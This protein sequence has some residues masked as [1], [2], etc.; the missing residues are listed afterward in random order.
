M[1]KLLLHIILILCFAMTAG[2]QKKDSVK[3]R[4]VQKL[5]D[6]A[7]VLQERG[8]DDS[9]L[10]VYQQALQVMNHITFADDP[11]VPLVYNLAGQLY[12]RKGDWEAAHH[13][14]SRALQKARPFGEV[15]YERQL[16][17]VSLLQLHRE[18]SKKDISF[19]YPVVKKLELADVW[20]P[21]LS[22][23]NAGDD[24][25][26][27]TIA[28]GRFDGVG[29]SL[30]TAELFTHITPLDTV[31]HKDLDFYGS[32]RIIR[33]TDNHTIIRVK[34]HQ[35]I[36]LL[37]GDFTILKASVPLAWR[38]LW[39]RSFLINGLNLI[40]NGREPL[41]HYR[42]LYYY[43]D[44]LTRD[45]IYGAMKNSVGEV[46]ELL[47]E[48]TLTH[49][50]YGAKIPSGIFQG[51]NIIRAMHESRPEHLEL[52]V[53][54]VKRFPA[55]YVGNDYRFSETYATWIINNTP[56]DPLNVKSFLLTLPDA[57][58]GSV[59]TKL[60]N[61]ILDDDIIDIWLDEGMRNVNVENITEAQTVARLM[62]VVS[63]AANPEKEGWSDYLF[64]NIERKLNHAGRA[65]SLLG[66]AE[67]KFQRYSLKEGVD[68]VR[69]TKSQWKNAGEI[70]VSVQEGHILPYVL[71]QARDPRYFA[72]GGAD[73]LIK[74]WDR[75]LG[76][77]ILT[78]RGHEEQV[79]A[80][81]YSP[82]G[83]Y[84][85]S[86]GED[87]L[88]NVWNAYNY[89]LLYQY[90][91]PTI[92]KAVRFTPDNRFIVTG[93]EDS[94]V[95]IREVQT[96]KIW[97]T[98]NL[99]K[100]AVNSLA[101]HPLYHQVLYSAG[102]D[103]FVYK[104]DINEGTMTRW[105]KHKGKALSVQVS[106]NGAYFSVVSS[107]SLMQ[108]WDSDTHRKLFW[109]KVFT[110]STGNLR[111]FA[112]ESFTPDSR[113]IAYPFRAD[114]F[115][116]I[117][118]K[119]LYERVYGVEERGHRLM[120]LQ[121]SNDGQAMFARYDLGGPLR[122]YN[123]VGWDIQN[124]PN[125]SWRDIRPF[126]NMVSSV[127][128]TDNDNSLVV[129]H[130]EISKLDLRNG[131]N[132]RLFWGY[133]LIDNPHLLVNG[134]KH[135]TY[136]DN[137]K[138][139][140]YFYD[141][142]RLENVV[143]FSLPPDE[144]LA[145]WKVSPGTEWVWLGS[146]QGRLGGWKANDSLPVFTVKIS[147]KGINALEYDRW[148]QK[149]YV[150]TEDEQ[151]FVVDPFTG[152]LLDSIGGVDGSYVACSPDF[153]YVTG[154]DGYL[155]KI[156]SADFEV[157]RK[158]KVSE[159]GLYQVAINPAKDVLSFISY[160]ELFIYRLS[161]DSLRFRFKDHEF[162]NTMLAISNDGKQIATA[163]LDSKVNLY[164]VASGKLLVNI[165]YPMN[166]GVL[167]SDANGHYLAAKHTLDA[168]QFTY[169]N[170]AYSFDQFDLRLNR[171]DIVLAKIGRAD[172][173][174][175][176]SFHNAFLKRLSRM[177][178]TEEAAGGEMHLPFV[179]LKDRFAVQAA[180]TEQEFEITVECSDSRY[181]LQYVQV[182]VNNNPVLGLKG[183]D[184]SHLRT[185]ATVQTIKVPL[186]QGLNRIKVFCT[187]AKGI[188]SLREDIEVLSKYR[189]E[190]A[191]RTY[192]V[193][194]GTASYKDSRMD[195]QYSVK[196]IRDLT[197]T[198]DD[199]YIDL[200]VDTLIDRKATRENILSLKK[201]LKQTSVND[202]VIL[203][204]TGHG[205]LSD[206]LD[207]Y[208]ATWDIDFNKPEKEG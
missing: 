101:F 23:I 186:S 140:V 115:V 100:G 90:K 207:F 15:F 16:A 62:R 185:Q 65:D 17:F 19:R 129:L 111:F 50:V 108:V 191:P 158:T 22:F 6:S 128:F 114:S 21:V 116:V 106:T 157:V 184:I 56:L 49:E 77:E 139:T 96:G 107:D 41:Y 26:D 30:K 118:I 68:W 12:Q 131:S 102:S 113:Y 25:L 126:G 138:P 136:I 93:G 47:A 20:F 149:L 178:L 162:A 202:R 180:T 199:L 73:K 164:D 144:K 1:K 172:S 32:G 122:I 13:H 33:V 57:E 135:G 165:H 194:I 14:F 123:F 79:T 196:D 117:R 203:A 182:L 169:N 55:K 27:V 52:F 120:D 40:S 75:T 145:T 24:S 5:V 206:S 195:L 146:E 2:A 86:V 28:G 46:V 141:Y 110:H 179:R 29:D 174:L 69:N 3:V 84:L 109:G 160:D 44:S 51:K 168:I 43:Y 142:R 198:F 45:D 188:S 159:G 81:E 37:R 183:M 74:I 98:L 31:Y 4:Q 18:L 9:A 201:K 53:N 192:F 54:F 70:K 64:A 205:L 119:D 67:L 125:I 88:V 130:S 171:P 63:R 147:D 161:D 35:Q 151:F 39:V 204:V 95:R 60:S 137:R 104:W 124:S 152:N 87:S 181:P 61:Q 91:S 82:N 94:V 197:K 85:V 176:R 143:S 42:Y 193:G 167:I 187:N 105:Y 150:I 177:K 132:E 190:R 154:K 163:G 38:N 153:I 112:S 7:T 134:G 10:L 208:Y 170:S 92:D 58:R 48:D 71:A 66:E 103:S 59:A 121:F 76:K 89:T 78:L 127:Q 36:T 80:L 97:K 156:S 155:Y 83:R 133:S 166:K 72:T 189:P 34:R 8:A 99:H 175:L 11:R 200:S 173:S 148:R